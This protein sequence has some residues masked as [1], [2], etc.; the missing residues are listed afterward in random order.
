MWWRRR[1]RKWVWCEDLRTQ[2]CVLSY[3]LKDFHQMKHQGMSISEMLTHTHPILTFCRVGR[4]M[5]RREQNITVCMKVP[6][7]IHKVNI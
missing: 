4:G 6:L 1:E 7:N 2:T 5:K 3:P